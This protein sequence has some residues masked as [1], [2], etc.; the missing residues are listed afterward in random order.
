MGKKKPQEDYAQNLKASFDRW[1]YLYEYGCN[2]PSWEDGVNLNLVR[3]H[4]IYYKRCI[5]D[6]MKPE[7]YPEIYYRAIPP[8]VPN[9]YVAGANEIREKA[10]A[11]LSL[12]YANKDYKFLTQRID[13][14]SPADEKRYCVRNVINYAKSL[15]LA[16]ENDDLVTMRRHQNPETYLSSFTSCAEKFKN[17]KPKENEQLTVFCYY[18]NSD[19]QDMEDNELDM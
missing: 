8:E 15:D 3:N 6:T 10:K 17:I 7:S 4:I 19:E 13:R 5:E 18:D 16:I 9:N 12:Y 2:D 14:L 11:S 1:Q